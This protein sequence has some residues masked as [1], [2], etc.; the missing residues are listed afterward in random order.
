MTGEM[1]TA[2]ESRSP[3]INSFKRTMTTEKD[4]YATYVPD[5]EPTDLQPEMTLEGGYTLIKQIGAGAMGVVW[6]AHDR[7]GDRLVALKFVP[8]ECSRFKDEIERLRK[9]FSKIHALNHQS[10]CPIYGLKEDSEFGFFLVMKFLDGETLDAHRLR[11][12][13][14]G[15]GLP[16][17][18]VLALL[19]PVASALDYAHGN[20]VI[21]R[22][23]KPANIFLSE[24]ARG[25]SVEIIDFGLAEEIRESM[26]RASQVK[27]EVSGTPGYMAPEQWKGA[28]QTAATDQYALA[29]IAYELLAGHLPF[30]GSNIENAVMKYDP[31]PI[32]EVSGA[33]NAALQTALAKR[34]DE[35]FASCQDFTNALA[36][37]VV[38]PPPPPPQ[39]QQQ[40]HQSGTTLPAP[41]DVAPLMERGHVHLEFS[42]WQ[43]ATRCFDEALNKASRYA[44][45]YVGLLCAELQL[46]K[47]EHL[48][49][50]KEPISDFPNFKKAIRFADDEYRKTLEGYAEKN[51]EC[52]RKLVVQPGERK[53]LSISGV[54]YPFRWC[55]SGTFM[56]GSPASETDRQA[57]ETHH[58][59]TLSRGFWLLETPVTQSMWESVMG[60]SP[61]KFTGSKKLPV[62]QVSWDDCQGFLQKLNG[63]GVAPDGYRFA[64]PTEAEWEYAC[65]AGTTTPFN[66]GSTLNGDKANCNGNY[67]YGTSTKGKYLEKTT[68]VD[69]YPANAWGLYDMHGNVLE[70]CHDWYGDYPSGA[71]TDPTGA[72]TGS[73]RVIRG[74]SWS[75]FAQYCRS[76]YRHDDD[77]S[78]R[79]S[80]CGVR[81]SLVRAE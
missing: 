58:Q 7:D 29:V 4:I 27:S 21:H 63:L 41:A 9:S 5:E 65:R 1:F 48:V 64:L 20:E 6:Q 26:I 44:P 81:L 39:P 53:V 36:G 52:I 16:L 13:P 24:T 69:S 61:S 79:F 25:V 35:R 47:E 31:E 57:N 54:E 73:D 22:D 78:Y 67:P 51:R 50:Y 38:V 62:E 74:G 30:S 34:G 17:E 2:F 23:I 76:A 10:I 3:T 77:P 71:V 8:K 28:R 43:Q 15:N 19:K 56:M 46:Q 59:V 14:K 40:P 49:D 68:D 12:D 11:K 33:A 37:A 60:S 42:E 55:P 45:V 72:T 80:A 32:R 66:F 18:Q 70:W 75:D